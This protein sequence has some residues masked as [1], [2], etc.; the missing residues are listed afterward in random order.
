MV[1]IL[2]LID[3]DISELLLIHRQH[4][5]M[6]LKETDGIKEDIVEVH[7]IIGKKLVVI[8][9]VDLRDRGHTHVVS[10]HDSKLLRRLHIVLRLADDRLNE[11]GRK[12]LIVQFHLL[13]TLF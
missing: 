12:E 3:E 13:D 9:A 6:L 10:G 7:G 5:R 4:I 1:R 8:S 2:I 11:P